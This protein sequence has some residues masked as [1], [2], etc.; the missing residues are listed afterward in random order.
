MAGGERVSGAAP[1]STRQLA[2]SNIDL[3]A[4]ITAT[5]DTK[6]AAIIAVRLMT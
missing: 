2:S 4:T 6:R 5:N 1:L 3:N